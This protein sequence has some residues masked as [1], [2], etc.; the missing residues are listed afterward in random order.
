MLRNQGLSG[1]RSRIQQ[2]EVRAM[3]GLA[4]L[5]DLMLVLAC[6]LMVSIILHWNVDI[7]AAVQVVTEQN[8]RE[9]KDL[10]SIVEDGSIFGALDSKGL[11]FEDP[12]TGKMY[13]ITDKNR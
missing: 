2:E 10:E 5:S 7:K 12:K 13:I 8:L 9:V 6:G 3:D 1:R 4:N 11:V